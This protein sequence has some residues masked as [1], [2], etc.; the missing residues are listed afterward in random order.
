[1]GVVSKQQEI[2]VKYSGREAWKE[3]EETAEEEQ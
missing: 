2:R 3:K 1:M